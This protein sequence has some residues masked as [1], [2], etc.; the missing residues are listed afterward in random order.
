MCMRKLGVIL[1]A[2][3]LVG[4]VGCKKATPSESAMG[5]DSAIKLASQ[6]AGTAEMIARVHWVGMQ[7]LSAE[8]N[9][10]GFMAIWM[11]PETLSL[12]AQTLSKLAYGLVGTN[13]SEN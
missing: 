6:N 8:T 1:W 13:A 10:A 3:V 11:M 5:A 9:A 12:K 2:G 7:R 4:M